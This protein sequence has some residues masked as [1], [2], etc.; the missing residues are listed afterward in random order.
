VYD[1]HK[2]F[3]G[4]HVIYAKNW[5]SYTDYGKILIQSREWM[6]TPDKMALTDQAKFMHCLP[7]RRNV[8]VADAVIDS[9]ASIILD[10]A[11]NRVVSCQA[12][13]QHMLMG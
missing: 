13:L 11:A 9:P 6:V 3:E 10:Q 1:Q 8:V 7:V 2:A 4:A 5:S 12:V